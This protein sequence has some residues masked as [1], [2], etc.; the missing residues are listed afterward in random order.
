MRHSPRGLH[1]WWFGHL[2]TCGTRHHRRWGCETCRWG[3]RCS[4][5]RR[6]HCTCS[7]RTRRTLPF[8]LVQRCPER[9]A[10]NWLHRLGSLARTCTLR[11]RQYPLPLCIYLRGKP[12]TSWRPRRQNDPHR[13]L[14]THVP[15]QKTCL[16]CTGCILRRRWP[17][18][19]CLAGTRNTNRAAQTRW[20]WRMA[21]TLA[22]C[23]AS[24]STSV[25]KYA[26][27]SPACCR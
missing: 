18:V 10:R 16:L 11:T 1:V 24:R 20:S 13:R 23:L 19:Q 8:H 7:A 14:R 15:W 17:R 12:S 5:T 3:T 27:Q 4:A 22:A 26:G 2:R 6:A 21:S 9:T 25:R